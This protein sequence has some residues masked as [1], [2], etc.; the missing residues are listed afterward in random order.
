MSTELSLRASI[1]TLIL[2]TSLIQLANGFFGTFFSLRVAV[3]GFEPWLAGP[4]LSAYFAGFTVGAVRCGAIIARIGH[5][6]AYAAFAGMVA[7]A[8][9]AMPLL[10]DPYAW[11]AL[12]AV[13]GFG[14]AGLFV[15]TESWLNAKA[16]PAGRGRV[17]S[18][19]MVGTFVALAA[20]QLLIAR[21]PVEAAG[22]FNA[23]V[24]LFAVA[25]VMVAG[26]RAEPPQALAGAALPYGQLARAAPVA[27]L[28]CALAG[29]ITGSFYALL[30][31]WM[32]GEGIARGTIALFMF[33]AV[34]GGLAFQVPVGRLSDRLDRRRVL[35]GLGLWRCSWSRAASP[36]SCPW[37]PC[38]AASCR[39]SIRS[40]SPTRTTG[41]PPT[42]SSPSAA[43]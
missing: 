18:I 29:L 27:V 24:A 22:A 38:S 9:A 40:A 41:C 39:P 32:E 8:T 37:R 4:V 43:G 30:P 35:A 25:L 23:I 26:T 21:I 5:I 12:R 31:A 19:Y 2:A 16:P 6:R 34:L 42:G 13:I 28:G 33:A 17:F 3:E 36:S 10:I 11:L 15:A 20:G 14:C 1:G 7:A